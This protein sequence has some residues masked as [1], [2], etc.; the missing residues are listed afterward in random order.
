MA[1]MQ[2]RSI[3]IGGHSTSVALE[4]A[5]WEE[6]TAQA[7]VRNLSVNAL[8]AEIDHKRGTANLAS[9]LRLY[10]L[11]TLKGQISGKISRA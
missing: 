9:A 3:K 11:E 8:I 2:K 6:L 4:P 5:F 1:P 10:V 7:G